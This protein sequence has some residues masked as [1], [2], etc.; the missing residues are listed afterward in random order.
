MCAYSQLLEIS[1]GLTLWDKTSFRVSAHLKLKKKSTNLID[2]CFICWYHCGIISIA[3][4]LIFT[5]LNSSSLVIFGEK[6]KKK[7]FSK[8]TLGLRQIWAQKTQEIKNNQEIYSLLV[9][10]FLFCLCKTLEF[11][12]KEQ[13]E[14]KIKFRFCCLTGKNLDSDG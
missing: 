11:C 4:E 13:K 6:I 8:L 3:N 5:I 12:W 1:H 14:K 10:I 9:V 2:F 7:A